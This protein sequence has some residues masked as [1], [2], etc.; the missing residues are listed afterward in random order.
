[1]DF[2]RRE[3]EEYSVGT[4]VIGRIR[5][6]RHEQGLSA[7]QLADVCVVKAAEMEPPMRATLTRSRISKLESSIV[8]SGLT[9]D[10]LW[11]VASAL[12]VFA[13]DLLPTPENTLGLADRVS[14]LEQ[15]IADIPASLRE[16]GIG[17]APGQE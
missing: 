5:A 6:L 7:Q 3:T 8:I 14:S 4:T 17:A 10:E 9:V 16:A 12:G 1:M 15:K 2:M 11:L 13:Q